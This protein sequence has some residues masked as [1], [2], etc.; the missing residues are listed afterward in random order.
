M[1][2]VVLVVLDCVRSDLFDQETSDP[3][4]MPFA[5]GLRAQSLRFQQA[6]APSSWTLPSHASLFTGLYPWDHGVHRKC[7]PRLGGGIETLAE[8]M[9]GAGYATA[10]FSANWRIQPDSGLT[11]GFGA[12]RWGGDKEFFLRFKSQLEASCPRPQHE[13]A[14][15]ER[16][17]EL[18]SSSFPGLWDA[19]NRVASRVRAGSAPLFPAVSRW[20]EPTVDLWL[21][22]QPADRPIF[23]FIN[24]CEA[25]EPYLANAG[26][27]LTL[28]EW[29]SFALSSQSLSRWAQ[30]RWSPGRDEIR[31]LAD[32]YRMTLRTLDDR[33]GRIVG[34]LQQHSRWEN[35]VFVVTSDHGQ[36]FLERDTLYHQYRVDEAITRIPL[37]I[38]VPGQVGSPACARW[39]SLIDVPRTISTFIGRE[40]FGDVSSKPL[41]EPESIPADRVVYSMSDG[42]TRA[43]AEALPQQRRLLLD[44]VLVAAYSGRYKVVWGESGEGQAY[45]V[46]AETTVS[47]PTPSNGPLV[48][49]N[50][51]TA[52]QN[53][54]RMLLEGAQGS[55]RQPDRSTRLESWGY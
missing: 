7:L 55:S 36:A 49:P 13:V 27:H 41:L 50:L 32:A 51:M 6:V 3:E 20:I 23:A 37:W 5:R 18:G 43:T 40:S 15:L 29:L 22:K 19:T 33:L 9:S 4:S 47:T 25:H 8:A 39:V 52:G 48:S 42:I 35:T 46:S 24:L 34:I 38:R 53:R 30:G 14:S 54:V 45:D 21:S 26:Y 16:A 31:R 28:R 1:L 17:L 10:S 11:R 44:Q 12:V 2:N